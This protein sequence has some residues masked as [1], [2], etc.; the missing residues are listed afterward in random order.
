LELL[1]GANGTTV[2]SNFS[3]VTNNQ[4]IILRFPIAG[5]MS[6][7]LPESEKDYFYPRNCH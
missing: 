5:A 3:D 2:L 4:P 6:G 7:E 1:G